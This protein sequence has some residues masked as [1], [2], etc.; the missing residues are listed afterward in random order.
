MVGLLGAMASAMIVA[1]HDGHRGPAAACDR[2]E[3]MLRGP[4]AS[5][6]RVEAEV[7]DTAATRA[8]G[9]KERRHLAWGRGML[10]LWPQPGDH[11]MWMA[12]T[13]ISLDMVFANGSDVV[14][15]VEGAEPGSRQQLG[16]DAAV[17]RVLEVRAGFV[18]RYGIDGSWRLGVAHQAAPVC[19]G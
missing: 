4:E 11:R 10:F 19:E 5:Q 13:Y 15:V 3:V 14:G 16:V 17:D 7:A 9:L 1:E 2:A 6:V 12:D 18:E 8:R